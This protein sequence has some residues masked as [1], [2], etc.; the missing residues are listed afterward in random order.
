VSPDSDFRFY[1]YQA[2]SK[3]EL[4]AEPLGWFGGGFMNNAPAGVH[5]HLK[6]SYQGSGP[7]QGAGFK[8]NLNPSKIRGAAG[9]AGVGTDFAFAVMIAHELGLHAIGG[10]PTHFHETGY[11][12]A[13]WGGQ[14]TGKKKFSKEAACLI[15]DK[16]DLQKGDP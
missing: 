2:R 8:A 1:L 10:K 14:L 4:D 12:D 15:L 13:N 11:V 6:D 3:E 9:D 16:M 5:V 7:G